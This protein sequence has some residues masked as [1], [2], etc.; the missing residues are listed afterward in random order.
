MSTNKIIIPL[1]ELSYEQFLELATDKKL[2]DEMKAKNKS[3]Y[4]IIH[5]ARRQFQKSHGAYG[6]YSDAGQDMI[7]NPMQVY[8]DELK[9]ED[10]DD[11]IKK[12]IMGYMNSLLANDIEHM[13]F[14][15]LP[16]FLTFIVKSKI[17]DDTMIRRLQYLENY[18]EENNLN[19]YHQAVILGISEPEQIIDVNLANESIVKRAAF[20]ALRKAIKELCYQNFNKRI[21]ENAN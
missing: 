16:D 5:N 20:I 2:I 6:Y 11:T 14:I 18:Y 21:L 12:K 15:V 17:N 10:V 13:P 8:E 4:S 19:D 1:G 3:I 9:K 7:P